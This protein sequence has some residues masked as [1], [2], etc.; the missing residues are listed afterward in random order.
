M[1]SELNISNEE[2]REVLEELGVED[3]ELLNPSK[4]RSRENLVRLTGYRKALER[5]VCCGSVSL[6][7]ILR[8]ILGT[9]LQLVIYYK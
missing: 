2:H 1:R 6:V 7:E 3:P 4:K 5:M 8:L 9:K